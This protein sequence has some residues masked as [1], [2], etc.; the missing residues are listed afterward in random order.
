MN[1]I[2]KITMITLVAGLVGFT[3]VN[4][5]AYW[6]GQRGY[7]NQTGMANGAGMNN[8]MPMRM[9]QKGQK[10]RFMNKNL[11]LTTDEAK[12]LVQARLIMRGNDRLKVG[13]VTEKDDTTYLVQIVTV[14]DSLVRELEIDRNTGRPLGAG[15]G[16]RA[17]FMQQ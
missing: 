7:C 4:A 16:A 2:A 15:R 9:K 8:G 13:K 3:A 1:K 17:G 10:G 12:T 11:N 5:D 14:D 6:G